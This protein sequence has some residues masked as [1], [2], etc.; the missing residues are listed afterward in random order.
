MVCDGGLR[1]RKFPPDR[2]IISL[3]LKLKRV[4]LRGGS[5]GRYRLIF[6]NSGERGHGK[7]YLRPVIITRRQLNEQYDKVT[8][9]RAAERLPLTVSISSKDNGQEG[10]KLM[11]K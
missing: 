10:C 4:S 5:T 8:D 2:P 9:L 11:G 7:Q 1:R 3:A 6:P